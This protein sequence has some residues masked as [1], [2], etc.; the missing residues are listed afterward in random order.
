SLKIGLPEGV[1]AWYLG[2]NFE[3]PA[4]IDALRKLGADVVGMSTVP[5]VLV[6]R[7]C[8]LR[9]A[10]IS[11]VTNLAAGMREGQHLSHDHTQAIAARIGANLAALLHAALPEIAAA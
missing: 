1:Y 9:V 2:P 7:H 10:A 8:G 3:T 6:A 5:E 11:A 4:E